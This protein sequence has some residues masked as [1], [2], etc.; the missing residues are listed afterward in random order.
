[1]VGGTV[2]DLR[3]LR[4]GVGERKALTVTPVRARTGALRYE[5]SAA[6]KLGIGLLA[7]TS[8]LAT[9]VRA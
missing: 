7:E 3:R 2:N 4:I 1:M 6:A 9:K 5:A 8:G